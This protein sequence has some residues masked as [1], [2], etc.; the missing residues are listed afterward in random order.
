MMRLSYYSTSPSFGS[1][2]YGEMLTSFPRFTTVNLARRTTNV[3]STDVEMTS[4]G[5]SIVILTIVSLAQTLMA[6]LNDK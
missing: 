2:L 6:L 1:L 5:L 4:V 3:F